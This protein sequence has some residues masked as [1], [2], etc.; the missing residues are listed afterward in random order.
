MKPTGLAGVIDTLGRGYAEYLHAHSCK[1]R[2]GDV[3]FAFDADNGSIRSVAFQ[4]KCVVDLPLNSRTAF[5]LADC[6]PENPEQVFVYEPGTLSLSDA[7]NSARCIAVGE[8]SR[9]AGPFMSR[10][11]V[12]ADCGSVA[13][14]L[15]SWV[16]RD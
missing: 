12:W 9:S 13:P 11:L 15:R 4:G 16:I 7:Q 5:G 8:V 2:G 6:D 10:D 3:Q 1:P 14:K